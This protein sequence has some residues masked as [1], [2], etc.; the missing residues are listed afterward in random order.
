MK[1]RSL[2]MAVALLLGLLTAL[3]QAWQTTAQTATAPSFAY[4]QVSNAANKNEF[5]RIAL[6]NTT[7]YTT[8]KTGTPPSSSRTSYSFRD[9]SGTTW[10]AQ[11]DFGGLSQGSYQTSSVAVSPKDGSVHLVWAEPMKKLAPKFATR[12]SEGV[13]A[14]STSVTP[15]L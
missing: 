2:Y 15:C 4:D 11:K 14:L 5:P 13:S 1:Q 10:P 9:E 12:R 6:G 3:P 7:L 8:W